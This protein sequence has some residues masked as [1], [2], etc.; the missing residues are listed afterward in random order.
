MARLGLPSLAVT[1][2]TLTLYRGIAQGILPSDTISGFPQGLASIGVI[3]IPHTHISYS[4]AFFLL[5]AVIFGTVLHATPLG[6][7]IFAIGANQESSLLLRHPRQADQ[8]LAVRPLGDGLR[9]RGS[10]RD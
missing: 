7:A 6:C 4:V 10:A 2:G 3:P 8:V 9:L 5:L 1:I